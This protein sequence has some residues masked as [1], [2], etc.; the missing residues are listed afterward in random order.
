[1]IAFIGYLSYI[2]RLEDEKL[3]MS[4]KYSVVSSVDYNAKVVCKRT[5]IQY[6]NNGVEY[7]ITYPY[8]V[9]VVKCY[10]TLEFT[11]NETGEKNLL[12]LS[13]ISYHDYDKIEEGM[14]IPIR[15]VIYNKNIEKVTFFESDLLEAL[16]IYVD[17]WIV[18]TETIYRNNFYIFSV[19]GSFISIVFSLVMLWLLLWR[20]DA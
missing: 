1:M 5:I 18:N 19:I 12:Y 17:E 10:A 14:I 13:N 20:I 16:P 11:D 4:K 7:S 8:T 15:R 3:T 6:V 9:N 2:I